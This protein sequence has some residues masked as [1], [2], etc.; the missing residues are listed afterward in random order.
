[1]RKLRAKKLREGN[2]RLGQW[3]RDL[4]KT[5]KLQQKKVAEQLGIHTDT[6]RQFESGE[7]L[8]WPDGLKRFCTI[9]SLASEERERLFKLYV[10][11]GNEPSTD[12][13]SEPFNDKYS[14]QG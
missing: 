6:L 10:I 9:L 4:R 8:P 3:M 7:Q 11:S 1:M 14:P 12:Y 13:P 5:R 2:P